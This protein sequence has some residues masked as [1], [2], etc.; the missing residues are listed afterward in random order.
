MILC[1]RVLFN[2]KNYCNDG[3]LTIVLHAISHLL[4]DDI[5]QLALQHE[6]GNARGYLTY[7]T[8]HTE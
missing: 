1:T 6:R 7:T 8:I 5:L 3:L 2:N 4:L